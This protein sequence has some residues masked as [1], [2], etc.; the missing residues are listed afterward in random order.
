MESLIFPRRSVTLR[1]GTERIDK[2]ERCERNYPLP[3]LYRE[4]AG[5]VQRQFSWPRF[6]HANIAA[7]QGQAFSM[8]QWPIDHMLNFFE[9]NESFRVRLISIKFD[10]C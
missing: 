9:R 10:F 6:F 5:R 1:K 8:V 7:P 2:E 3:L 4:S